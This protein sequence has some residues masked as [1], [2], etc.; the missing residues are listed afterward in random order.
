LGATP[1]G[2]GQWQHERINDGDGKLRKIAVRKRS[3][4]V[5]EKPFAPSAVMIERCL[6]QPTVVLEERD[7]FLRSGPTSSD[8]TRTAGRSIVGW[9]VGVMDV[10]VDR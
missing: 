7:V 4:E 2:P 6:M 1:Q 9:I 3:C 8:R 5:L 10:P